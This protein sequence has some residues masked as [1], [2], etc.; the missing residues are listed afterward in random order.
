MEERRNVQQRAI[1][2]R[3]G[4]ARS[5]P[6]ES[7]HKIIRVNRINKHVLSFAYLQYIL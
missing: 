6:N 1:V 3:A 2:G 7:K 4:E 5:P